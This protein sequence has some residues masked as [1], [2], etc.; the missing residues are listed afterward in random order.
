[1][2]RGRSSVDIGDSW[3]AE[4]LLGCTRLAVTAGAGG[5]RGW[6]PIALHDVALWLSSDAIREGRAARDAV[7]TTKDTYR[8]RGPNEA[9]PGA[10]PKKRKRKPAGAAAAG[11]GAGDD[12]AATAGNS[13]DDKSSGAWQLSCV[14]V[15]CSGSIRFARLPRVH[16]RRNVP[17]V[18]ICRFARAHRR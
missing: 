12:A 9:A 6:G 13:G 1:M 2:F 8:K 5:G 11:G 4:A 16:R 17:I 10:A 3:D 18:L 7:A 15:F 14:P